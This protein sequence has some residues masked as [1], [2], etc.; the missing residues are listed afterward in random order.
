MGKQQENR[1]GNKY[2]RDKKYGLSKREIEDLKHPMHLVRGELTW[3]R[4]HAQTH[5]R[6]GT[7]SRLKA[8]ADSQYLALTA[9]QNA[10]F[11]RSL[12][13]HLLTSDITILHA[14]PSSKNAIK[15]N[16]SGGNMMPS[17]VRL[18]ASG[19]NNCQRHGRV[20]VSTWQT[21]AP[22]NKLM[23]D[24]LRNILLLAPAPISR[25]VQR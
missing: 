16:E 10:L 15:R 5:E 23:Q 8:A 12:F 17:N 6:N 20:E 4:P 2:P 14:S 18:V 9:D 19:G 3:Q 24:C 11:I 22:I 25:S 7:I 1:K 21:P 13:L